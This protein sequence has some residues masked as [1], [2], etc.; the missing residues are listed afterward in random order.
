MLKFAYASNLSLASS[1]FLF[2]QLF[3]LLLLPPSRCRCRAQSSSSA[4]SVGRAADLFWPGPGRTGGSFHLVAVGGETT[5]RYNMAADRKVCENRRRP[6][7]RSH[8]GPA[9]SGALHGNRWPEMGFRLWDLHAHPISLSPLSPSTVDSQPV[10][11]PSVCPPAR[12]PACLPA[13]LLACL[14]VSLASRSKLCASFEAD[15]LLNFRLPPV[16]TCRDSGAKLV[17]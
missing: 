9:L 11:R 6:G 10:G 14:S 2:L 17:H 12:P 7:T 1:L 15:W 3:I 5:T 13:R 4:V 16:A 8:R